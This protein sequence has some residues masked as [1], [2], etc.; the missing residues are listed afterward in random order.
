MRYAQKG[1][2]SGFVNNMATV[3]LFQVAWDTPRKPF[4]G[5]RSKPSTLYGC[6]NVQNSKTAA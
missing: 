2:K 1:E 3:C 5:R 4:R 6:Q